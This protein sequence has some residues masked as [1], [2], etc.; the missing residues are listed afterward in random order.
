[1]RSL[2]KFQ[3]KLDPKM[4]QFKFFTP[5]F[6]IHYFRELFLES[7]LFK[8]KLVLIPVFYM[9]LHYLLVQHV[10]VAFLLSQPFNSR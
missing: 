5:H 1:M 4:R 9:L 7:F 10:S 3:C 8:L 2:K 6:E